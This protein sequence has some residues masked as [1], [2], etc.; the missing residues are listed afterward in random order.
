MTDIACRC[1]DRS[2]AGNVSASLPA[3]SPEVSSPST[4]LSYLEPDHMEEREVVPSDAFDGEET[5]VEEEAIPVPP[6]RAVSGLL[7]SRGGRL[8]RRIAPYVSPSGAPRG[9]GGSRR[10]RT[11]PFT[12][13]H[14][15]VAS[16]QRAFSSIFGGPGGVGLDN[17]DSSEGDAPSSDRRSAGLEY[18]SGPDFSQF[19]DG[20]RDRGGGGSSRT[21]GRRDG[22]RGA[23]RESLD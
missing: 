10:Q 4:D 22:R 14:R 2:H 18:E 3:S 15:R 7:R 6:P 17:G 11:S 19:S 21:A 13:A 8:D 5:A 23:R 16:G 20:G 9:V 12:R 1:G